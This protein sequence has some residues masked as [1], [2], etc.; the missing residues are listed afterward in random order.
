MSDTVHAEVHIDEKGRVVIP[1]AAR[2]AAGIHGK[3]NMHLRVQG[4]TLIL[5]PREQLWKEI[6]DL[7]AGIPYS[8]ADSL[9]EDRR[10]EVERERLADQEAADERRDA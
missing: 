6:R 4:G 1:A 3:T 5:V 8:L 10:A 7:M 2:R 9:I